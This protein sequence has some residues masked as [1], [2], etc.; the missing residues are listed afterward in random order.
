METDL[1]G[2]KIHKNEKVIKPSIVL[3]NLRREKKSFE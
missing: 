3:R 1:N 2:K